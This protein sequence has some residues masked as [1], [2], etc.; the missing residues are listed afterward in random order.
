ME[1]AVH[2]FTEPLVLFHETYRYEGLIAVAS[3]ENR[4]LILRYT[5]LADGAPIA[6]RCVPNGDKADKEM[7]VLHRVEQMRR[8]LDL[9]CV[10]RLHGYHPTSEDPFVVH[11]DLL[12][13]QQKARLA[14][15]DKGAVYDLYWH[16]IMDY[17]PVAYT[18]LP[19]AE[20]QPMVVPILVDLLC[21]LW[22]ARVSDQFFHGDAHIK[23]IMFQ[24]L[25]V[26][27]SRRT[28][29]YTVDGMRLTVSAPYL[30]VLIDFDHSKFG[31]EDP[32]EKYSD[33]RF[34]VGAMGV[35]MDQYNIKWP[36]EYATLRSYSITLPDSRFTPEN[37]P[38]ILREFPLFAAVREE[39]GGQE[40]P[41]KRIKDCVHC[42][43]ALA[44]QQCSRCG[45]ALCSLVCS[46]AAW[47]GPKKCHM[48][49]P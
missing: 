23:N 43:S 19:R 13:P 17:V 11:E 44:T 6:V 48:N 35:L 34:V 27:D 14:K 33:V 46:R 5:R 18:Q 3:L 22:Q 24:P 36:P 12:T 31:T 2:S 38:R 8:R 21:T 1:D 15:E 7:S 29:R 37:I 45:V 10:V 47:R 9:Q 28:R 25:G 16:I 49:P 30:P 20:V 39:A 40:Q 42:G 41:L 4:V 26:D 32:D